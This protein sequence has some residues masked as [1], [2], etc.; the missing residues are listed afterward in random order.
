[1]GARRR[2]RSQK[3]SFTELQ[4]PPRS[5]GSGVLNSPAQVFPRRPPTRRQEHTLSPPPLPPRLPLRFLHARTEAS[6]WGIKRLECAASGCSLQMSLQA[7]LSP[8]PLPAERGG[9]AK[10]GRSL[11]RKRGKERRGG[12]GICGG[13]E[14][15]WP[16]RAS[17][18]R[19]D[20]QPI[21]SRCPHPRILLTSSALRSLLTPRPPSPP[22]PRFLPLLL[23][24]AHTQARTN[25]E[26]ESESPG[27]HP[28]SIAHSDRRDGRSAARRERPPSTAAAKRSHTFMRAHTHTHTFSACSFLFPLPSLLLSLQPEKRGTYR[29]LLSGSESLFLSHQASP[30]PTRTTALYSL[31]TSIKV[32]IEERPKKDTSGYFSFVFFLPSPLC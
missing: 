23:V 5:P 17:C 22:P 28:P 21:I 3:A 29:Y 31:F 4:G 14:E 15:Q 12:E 10:C 6:E 32:V 19:C 9:A 18:S 26:G 2:G 30:P 27:C 24:T 13:K 1:M 20:L 7:A 16:V 11:R 8:H 25:S